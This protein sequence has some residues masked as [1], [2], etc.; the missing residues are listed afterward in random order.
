[1]P[2]TLFRDN[3]YYELYSHYLTIYKYDLFDQRYI[4][5]DQCFLQQLPRKYHAVIEEINRPD[6]KMNALETN[7]MNIKITT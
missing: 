5:I 1:M 3:Y 7:L 4:K 2:K 6:I